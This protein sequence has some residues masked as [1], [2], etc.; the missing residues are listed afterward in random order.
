[1]YMYTIKRPC[2]TVVLGSVS[3]INDEETMGY[4]EPTHINVIIYM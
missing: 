1:M 4:L 2:I 3:G